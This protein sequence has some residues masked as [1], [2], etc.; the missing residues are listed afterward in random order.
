M[1]RMRFGMVMTPLIAVEFKHPII[2]VAG[3]RSSIVRVNTV[4]LIPL[5]ALSRKFV[6]FDTSATSASTIAALAG[7][8]RDLAWSIGCCVIAKIA[9]QTAKAVSSATSESGASALTL[10][11]CPPKKH[12]RLIGRVDIQRRDAFALRRSR[13]RAAL[14]APHQVN[15]ERAKI[16]VS[17]SVSPPNPGQLEP[18]PYWLCVRTAVRTHPQCP[19]RGCRWH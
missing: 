14:A 15:P 16:L 19:T 7:T 17:C 8:T 11:V 10:Y 13:P 4:V 2:R 9:S 6:I 18:A 12:K 5:I 3:W 1:F